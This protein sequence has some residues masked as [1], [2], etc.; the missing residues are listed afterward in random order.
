MERPNITISISTV[1]TSHW[2][3]NLPIASPISTQGGEKMFSRY[4]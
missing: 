1:S 2:W 4:T 3:R